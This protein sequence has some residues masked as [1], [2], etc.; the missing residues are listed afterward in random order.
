V[1]TLSS[2]KTTEWIVVKGKQRT[3]PQVG[4]RVELTDIEGDYGRCKSPQGDAQILSAICRDGSAAQD[5]AKLPG[6]YS[7][8]RVEPMA[9]ISGLTPDPDAPDCWIIHIS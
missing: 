1:T 8:E 9:D 7:V 6:E 5:Y 4:D 3:F 2:A